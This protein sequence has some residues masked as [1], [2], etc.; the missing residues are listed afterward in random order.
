MTLSLA[1]KRQ[2]WAILGFAVAVL[3]LMALR[4]SDYYELVLTQVLLWAAMSLAWNILSGYS[5]YFSFGHAVFWGLGAYT[6]ALGLIH[7]DLTPW[8]TIPAG[9]R[10]VGWRLDRVPDLPP[11]GPLFRIGDARLPA[12]HPLCF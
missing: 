11:T 12:R 1:V 5:G 4:H 2:L 7:F 6:V 3:I 8:L 9:R 10:W